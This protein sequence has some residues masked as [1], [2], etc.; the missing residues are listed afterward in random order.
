MQDVF[1][2]RNLSFAPFVVEFV[3]RMKSLSP[4]AKQ[5]YAQELHTRVMRLF[6]AKLNGS[7]RKRMVTVALEELARLLP[8]NPSNTARGQ[9][10]KNKRDPVNDL[11]IWIRDLMTFATTSSLLGKRNNPWIKDPSLVEAYW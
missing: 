10:D 11:W 5:A 4:H 8:D 6:A 2:N 9:G 3:Y 1:R 7:A